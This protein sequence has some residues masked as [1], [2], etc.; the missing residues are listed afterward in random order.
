MKLVAAL[1]LLLVA[2]GG[3]SSTSDAGAS[4]SFC[5]QHRVEGFEC[6]ASSD[7]GAVLMKN[8]YRCASCQGVDETGHPTE[9]P[10]GCKTVAGNDLCVADC[11]ECS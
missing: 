1:A 6:P 10:V 5:P 11:G 3:S 8:G 9:K 7:A 2:C 4:I